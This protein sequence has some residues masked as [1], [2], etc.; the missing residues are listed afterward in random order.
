MSGSVVTSGSPEPLGVTLDAGGVNVAV[1]SAHAEAIEFCLFDAS[2][3]REITRVRLPE[4]SGD[5]FHGHIAGVCAG[6][7]Y[8]LRAHGPWDPARGHRFNAAKLLVDPFATAIDRSFELDPAMFDTD[9]PNPADSAAAMPKG[10]VGTP[11]IT[12]P[13]RPPVGLDRQIIY[14]LHVRG[15]TRLHPDIP[16]PLRGTF[17]G[18][19][20]PAAIE[21]L[22]RL[23]IA[24]VELM[25]CAAWLDERHLPPLGLSNY[26]GYNPVAFLAPDPRLAPGGWPEIRAAVAALQGAGIA[27][28][29]DVVFNHTGEGDELGPT[30]SLRGLDNASYYRLLPDDPSRY[31]NDTGCGHTLALDR[32]PMLRLA[33]EA[34]RCWTTRAGIDGFRFDLAT[35]LGRRASGFDSEAPLFEA[36]D[37]DP[38]L[39]DRMLIAEP[40]DVGEGGYRL[41]G[42]PDGWSEWND[43]FRDTARRFWRGDAGMVGEL[44]TRVA[45]SADI[46]GG[47][48]RPVSCSVNFITAHDG[49]TLADL[50][51][52]ERKH[53]E[54][55][56]EHNRDGTDQNFSWNRGVEGAT[57]DPGIRAVRA[58]DARALLATLLLARGTPMLT[59][60]D[61]CGRTQEGNN[62]AYS[63]D[64]AI[65]WFDWAGADHS[66][67]AFT[68]RLI[69]ARQAC[70]A[71]TGTR[72]LTGKPV[73]E[74]G[75]PDVAWRTPDGRA[76][77]VEDWQAP[78]SRSLVAVLYEAGSRAVLVLHAGG[79]PIRVALPTPRSE[80]RWH[81]IADSRQPE[82]HGP[83]EQY[84]EAGPRSVLFVV[85]T[86]VASG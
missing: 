1:W 79:G 71:L 2:G 23:G 6:A 10:I 85:E 86:A 19:A 55:N 82:V 4:R 66:L 7:R 67:A 63:Q 38:V 24:A 73:D 48:H 21:H 64:N 31:V 37:Q 20:H 11:A 26:W 62:N 84:V 43:R 28:L 18:L 49:F 35:T 41:G 81:L 14:E 15:F 58:G 80:H 30:V 68:A 51:S 34:L 57:D 74:S 9:A 12:T 16:A 25:P 69:A 22:R 77:A 61:E 60:G 75:V 44:A 52:H 45:G 56:G 65:S 29:L 32:P 36:I 47:R 27:V 70:G 59:M 50:V 13:R 8:G 78:D 5:V 33:M 3:D 39:R 46:F 17:A 53:N 42:F 40:W 83:V 72:P 76:M 54:A